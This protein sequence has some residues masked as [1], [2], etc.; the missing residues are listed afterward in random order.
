MFAASAICTR[1]KLNLVS[2]GYRA[3]LSLSATRVLHL[4][5]DIT[6]ATLW[7]SERLAKAIKRSVRTVERALAELRSL[8]VL[9]TVRRRRQ[10]L[11]K[12]LC[13]EKIHALGM[14]GAAA[15]RKACEAAVSMLKS[16][17]TRQSWRPISKLE[18][19]RGLIH[20][21]SIAKSEKSDAT[22]SLLRA[23]GMLPRPRR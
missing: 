20:V 5:I 19:N 2:I 12:S 7:S 23:M 17:L 16:G 21:A 22:A 18:I 8:G 6:G 10:T 13:P 3:D 9:K 11:V 15:S 1:E 14:A 4:M